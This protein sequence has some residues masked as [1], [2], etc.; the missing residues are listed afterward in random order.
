MLQL[1]PAA[2]EVIRGNQQ[3][4]WRRRKEERKTVFIPK[5][6]PT[7]EEDVEEVLFQ[8]LSA[9]RAKLAEKEHM[10]AY[11][12]FSNAALRDMCRKSPAVWQR[13]GRF[14]ALGLSNR[15]NTGRRLSKKLQRI[16]QKNR[17]TNNGRLQRRQN[18]WNTHLEQLQIFQ[19]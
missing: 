7:V 1:T 9:L 10:P 4:L 2:A 11:I 5:P 6:K 16:Q 15:R 14:L 3:V 8:R 18:Q 13:F 17:Q 19:H 12:V